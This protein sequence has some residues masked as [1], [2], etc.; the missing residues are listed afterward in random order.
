MLRQRKT[1][2][3]RWGKKGL[4]GRALVDGKVMCWKEEWLWICQWSFP[5][6]C[7]AS[8][9]SWRMWK[10]GGGGKSVQ[11]IKDHSSLLSSSSTFSFLL[12]C[13]LYL[14]FLPFRQSSNIL[15]KWSLSVGRACLVSGKSLNAPSS[16]MLRLHSGNELLV[17][18]KYSVLQTILPCERELRVQVMCC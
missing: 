11:G 17:P 13:F 16:K 3:E 15:G 10:K 9:P 5:S 1:E 12:C 14:L 18:V 7:P 4:V 2:R 8:F 6:L